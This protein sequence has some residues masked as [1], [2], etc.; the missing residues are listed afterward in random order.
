LLRLWKVVADHNRKVDHI[1][2]SENFW[3]VMLKK[4]RLEG[5]D[6]AVCDTDLASDV[7]EGPFQIVQSLLVLYEG[8]QGRQREC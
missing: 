6:L 7:G 1:A 8:M 5:L 2:D 4:K 3:R